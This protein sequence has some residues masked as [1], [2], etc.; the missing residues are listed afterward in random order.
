VKKGYILGVIT[1]LLLF[2]AIKMVNRKAPNNPQKAEAPK[3][4]KM[5]LIPA[6]DAEQQMRNYQPVADY[7]GQ[8]LGVKVEM[9]VTHDYT[10]AIEAMRSKH[11]DMAWYGPFSYVL[12]AKEAGAEALVVGTRRDT[13]KS[14][15]KTVIVTRAGSGIKT[16]NDLKKRTF[17]FVDPAS[18]SGN[19]FPRLVFSKNGIDPE[20]DFKTI[21]YAGTHNGVELAIKNK[22]V[23]AGADSDTSYN[24]MVKEGQIDPKVNVIIYESDPIPGSPIAIRSDL[25]EELK[26]TIKEALISMDQQTFYKVQGWGDIEK[27]TEAKDS[28]YDVVREVA[29]ILNLDLTK[30]K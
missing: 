3:V 2:G 17:A 21:I 6:D 11:I 26:K 10:S 27:Y 30:L 20:K 15:Y 24:L 16:L 23:D 9:S 14:T 4:L 1:V 18:T 13:G 22:T 7:L 19:L 25:P 8:K 12:A 28:D 5:G 29:K